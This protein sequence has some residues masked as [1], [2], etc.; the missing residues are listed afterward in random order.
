MAYHI[1]PPP[2]DLPAE[3]SEAILAAINSPSLQTGTVHAQHALDLAQAQRN[4]RAIAS[5]GFT[6]MFFHYRSG[7]L[8]HALELGQRVAPMLQAE[9]QRDARMQLL[10][11]ICLCACDLGA[12]D[13]ALKYATEAYRSAIEY[14][15]ESGKALGLNLLG[16]TFDRLGDAWQGVRLLRSAVELARPLD[17]AR[18]LA[19]TINNLVAVLLE[20]YYLLRDSGAHDDARAALVEALPL[21][22]ES[23][24][25]VDTISE[26][27]F[28]SYAHANI[29]ELLVH[30]GDFDEA[31]VYLER[32]LARAVEHGLTTI[33]WRAR[34]AMGDAKLARGETLAA[35]ELMQTLATEIGE[36]IPPGLAFH[37]YDVRYR[38]HRKLGQTEE[39]LL[40]LEQLRKN[41]RERA[42]VQLRT[43]S[44]LLV[45]RLEADASQRESVADAY[46]IARQHIAK[47]AEMEHMALHDELTKLG[48]RRLLDQRLPTLVAN[49]K[50]SRAP[51]SIA[52][53]DLDH[54]KR[55]NDHFGHAMGDRVLVQI[56]ALLREN[57]R[58]SDLVARTGGEEFVIVIADLAQKEAAEL[59]ERLRH[60]VSAFAWGT[61][62][63]ELAVTLSIGVA[64]TPEYDPIDLL[65]RADLQM[66]RAKRA[67]RNRVSVA[68]QR[69]PVGD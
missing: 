32:S 6:R 22:R 63:P 4:P 15:S 31:E 65:E 54:F 30:L 1:I 56:A 49:A 46:E 2:D 69:T 25:L 26:P 10:R 37:V 58:S 35:I 18:I 57:T 40:A 34:R 67:G 11:W 12:L 47:A 29:G 17:Q 68:S 43:Q 21:A 3:I 28:T 60:R 13:V 41:E 20:Q 36:Q 5:A 7:D 8:K 23:I 27:F 24:H 61:I 53:T 45:T 44:E 50:R 9:G 33:M 59:C 42:I 38:A 48:N 51:L 52:V 19:P 64:S 39:A 66:Y 16:F 62:A 14:Q 55:I